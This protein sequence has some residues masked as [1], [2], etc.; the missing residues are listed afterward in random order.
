[1]DKSLATVMAVQQ[2]LPGVQDLQTSSS[3]DSCTF[4]PAF[5]AVL[6]E[7]QHKD[8]LKRVTETTSKL[9]KNRRIV[10]EPDCHCKLLVTATHLWPGKRKLFLNFLSTGSI[11]NFK[12]ALLL[13]L[14]LNVHL[15]YVVDIFDSEFDEWVVLEEDGWHEQIKQRAWLRLVQP[16]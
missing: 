5:M 4:W 6:H 7:P 9:E 14:K 16:Y 3:M 8:F 12:D 1:M 10:K 2:I 13:Q 15:N 11:Q